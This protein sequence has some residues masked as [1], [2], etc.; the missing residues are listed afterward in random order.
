MTS[1]EVYWEVHA[2]LAYEAR[3]L[4]E[5]RYPEWLD[6]FC[7][8]A[9]YWVPGV[10]NRG[11]ADTEGSYAPSRMAYFDDTLDDLRR[12]VVRFTAP[13]AWAEDPATRHL[14]VVSN[15]EVE[16]ADTAGELLVRSVIVNYRGQGDID[17]ATLYGRREDVLRRTPEGLRIAR[18]LVVLRHAVLPAKNINTFF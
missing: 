13:T 16:G 18:R 1:A 8:D 12:R 10:E 7:D 9:H 2:F 6:L 15:I 4:D 11:R 14:H 5:E 3:L 17:A